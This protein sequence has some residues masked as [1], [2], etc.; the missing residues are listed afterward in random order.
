M[1]IWFST[2]AKW[3]ARVELG[4]QYRSTRRHAL[5]RPAMPARE[6]RSAATA[7]H[8]RNSVAFQQRE[9]VGWERAWLRLRPSDPRSQLTVSTHVVLQT[10][11]EERR[12]GKE[13]T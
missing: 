6:R 5:P 4:T 11:S 2:C 10:R 8:P 1:K 13:S 9:R 3:V 7:V 12:V